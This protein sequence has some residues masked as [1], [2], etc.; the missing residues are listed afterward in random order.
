VPRP[1]IFILPN[2][3]KGT[4]SVVMTLGT[5]SR[6]T[7]TLAGSG[8]DSLSDMLYCIV[9]RFVVQ[10]LWRQWCVLV[11]VT[12]D[13]MVGELLSIRQVRSGM[14]Q[15]LRSSGSIRNLVLSIA[16]GVL[17]PRD[18]VYRRPERRHSRPTVS[19]VSSSP[20]LM[21]LCFV[22]PQRTVQEFVSNVFWNAHAIKAPRSRFEFLRTQFFM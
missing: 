1:P 8:C 17:R 11:V 19:S 4:E 6:M 13:R 3:Q 18:T 5:T 14:T 7:I 15:C 16:D 9:V 21:C 12:R 22:G 2:R 10:I 20:R